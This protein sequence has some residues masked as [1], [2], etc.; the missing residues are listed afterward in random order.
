[1]YPTNW[2][3][4]GADRLPGTLLYRLLYSFSRSNLTNSHYNTKRTTTTISTCSDKSFLR[5]N[6]HKI[7][8]GSKNG[9]TQLWTS[10]Q[11]TNTKINEWGTV[12]IY[13][14]TITTHG[15]TDTKK[16]AQFLSIRFGFKKHIKWNVKSEIRYQGKNL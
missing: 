15:I 1:M 5:N 14:Q 4:T 2:P 13:A 10:A 12:Q 9:Q 6:N 7:S 3:K 11:I 16:K 8:H